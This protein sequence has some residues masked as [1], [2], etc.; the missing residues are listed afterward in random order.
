MIGDLNILIR[1]TSAGEI[2]ILSVY[3]DNFL[4]ASNHVIIL[5]NLKEALGQKYSIKDLGEIKT[6]I[7]WQ[8]T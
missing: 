5:D 8:I 1:H 6:I 7:G 4:L 2:I 3:F